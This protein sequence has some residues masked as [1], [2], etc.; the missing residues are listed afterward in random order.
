MGKIAVLAA[1]RRDRIFSEKHYDSLRRHGDLCIYDRDDFEDFSYVLD[2]VKGAEVII[3]S[4]GT[5]PIGKEI[6]D[7][8]PNLK[9]VAHAAG[10]VKPVATDMMFE[11]GV[12]ISSASTA[13]ADGVAEFTLGIAIAACKRV[14]TLSRDTAAGLW[15]E[16][17][18]TVKD[19]YDIKFGIVSAGLIGRKV[20]K[21]LKN[22]KID[23]LVYDPF[24]T[25]DQIR[26]LGGTKCELERLLSECD[27]ISVHTPALPET[28][29]MFNKNN[30]P[31]IKD[32][33][34]LINTARGTLFDEEDLTAELKKNRFFACLDVL[35]EE[36]PSSDFEIRSLPNVILTP[37]IA[38]TPTNGLHRIGTH[39]CEEI[40]RYFDNLPMI[41]EVK[42]E[43]LS[44]MA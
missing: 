35:T 38:G 31:L 16:N 18:E 44:R 43:L 24:F 13:L 1:G 21:L 6:L 12:R 25:E 14:F 19:F 17:V 27:I 15:R 34:V 7:V 2:F 11:R 20:M 36:P 5:P 22:F 37:H 39:V 3:S 40:D 33:A 8:C 30:L 23:V 32:G 42:K 10:S 41:G 9:L 26:E 28:N 4:W 29:K